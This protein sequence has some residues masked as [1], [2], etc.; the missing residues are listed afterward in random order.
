[1]RTFLV[2]LSI[3]CCF[4]GPQLS[5]QP[6]GRENFDANWKFHLGDIIGAEGTNFSDNGWRSLDLPH[7]WSIEGSFKPDNP[8]TNSG[9]SL[10]GGIGWYRKNFTVNGAKSK[11]RFIQFDGVYMNSTVWINGH[12]LG[13]RP[14][15]Y[16]TF[17]YDM[18]P[19]L[20]EGDN[21]ISVKVDNSLQPN[22]RWYSGSGIYRHVWLSTTSPLHVSQWGTYVTTPKVS[23]KE[24][25][26]Q[27]ETSISNDN[28][29]KAN[30]RIVSTIID[31]KGNKIA[32]QVQTGKI[33]PDT[34][35]KIN[36]NIKVNA[37]QL[38][39]IE[40]PNLYQLT[41]EV[42]QGKELKDTYFTTF[43]I[44]SV[45]FRSDSGFFLNNKCVKVKGVCVHHD[46]GCLGAALNTRALTR[47]LEI[48]KSM[49]CNGIR[50]SH[51]PPSPDLL[52][53]CDKMGFLVM[54]EAFDVWY[55]EKMKYDYHIYF[56]DWHEH[57]LSDMVLRDRN[58]PSVFLWSIGNEIPEKNHSKYGGAAIAKE[59]D[60][61]I[62]K[63][64]KT[65]FTTSAFAGVWRADT[66]FMTDKV[67]VIGINYTVERYSEEKA[68]HPNGFF[69]ASE[70]TSSL[71]DRGIYHFPADS[72]MQAT[73]D[74]H[75]S[76]FDN[77]GTYYD[78]PATMI[79]QTTWRAV[80]ETPYV[81]GLFVW[82]GFD[83]LGEP[84]YPYPCIS[85]SYGIIDLCG[86]P[87]DV[88]Y[89]Y[90]SQWTNEPVLHLFPHWNWKVGALIDVVAYTNCDGIKLYLN[91]K[92]IGEQVFANT[93]I[94]YQTRQWDKVIN[95]GQGQKSSLD[96]KVPFMPGTL[97]AEG[98]KNGKLIATDIV[99]T[100]G[101]PAKIELVADRSAIA[102]DGKD[103]SYITVKIKDSKGTLV[104]EADNL[105]HFDIEGEGKIVG[106]ANGNPISI[107]PAKGSERRAFSGMCLVVI[108]S[109]SKNGS[110]SLKASSL[111]LP[112]EKISLLSRD[113][114]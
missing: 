10:P 55:L 47:Q 78:R 63:Y 75:C 80:K 39:S 35:L 5:A 71:S 64:D 12:K 18:T 85:S 97:R 81:A 17:Q 83:Y 105:V 74:M 56:K 8:A 26:V 9:A 7:D 94:T 86:F 61:I 114:K 44:R 20:K 79:T 2:I 38:W 88:F 4:L 52:D 65:R 33:E 91:D 70:T 99:K 73:S 106:V 22:S 46:L 11:H 58:H 90:K 48:L 23:A 6:A 51:N 24:A 29:E 28:K 34:Q 53:L 87:K 36:M 110:I 98:Y 103:L 42:Y 76:S 96:W 102:A 25:L 82:T 45:V 89:F 32:S 95:L 13:N 104:P 66:T 111:G 60:G 40:Q 93:N 62:K 43:G 108:Q 112:D 68:K 69:I 37:P 14:F 30:V 72:A 109:T 92:L 113:P 15:G 59:L 49:G 21:V 84:A 16:S 1:M 101:D 27:V 100:A 41:S 19:Y 107:E 31:N 54:D 3:I 77:R 50:T 67:D 57:D